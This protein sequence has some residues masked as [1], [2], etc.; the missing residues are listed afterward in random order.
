MQRGE[1]AEP[2]LLFGSHR[3]AEAAVIPPYSLYERLESLLEDQQLG[4]IAEQRIRNE[5][6]I[7]GGADAARALGIDLS[8]LDESE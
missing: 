6:P 1:S 2:P 4:K 5:A 3:R 8:E 7:S